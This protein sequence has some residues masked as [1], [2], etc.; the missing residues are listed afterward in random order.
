MNLN[1]IAE[2]SYNQLFPKGGDESSIDKVEFQRTA[3]AEFSYLTWLAF[4]NEKNQ[5]GYAE[6]P[7]YLLSEV[8]KEV[9]NNEMD[10]SDLKILRSLP[11]EVWLQNL[12][13]LSCKCEYVKSTINLSQALCDDDSMGDNVRTYYVV[14]N[15]IRFPKGVH[16]SP[17]PITFANMG[18]GVNGYIEIDDAIGGIVRTRLIEIYGGKIG[19]EDKTNNSN[20]TN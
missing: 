12:G 16:T 7:S 20:S 13:G 14:G 10:I 15:K 6:V 4:L 9:V 11:Q 19:A 17:L 18:N 5:E 3:F 8:E 2:L 1:E